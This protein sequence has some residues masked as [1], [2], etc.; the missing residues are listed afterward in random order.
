M[1][2]RCLFG[3]S[4]PDTRSGD[5]ESWVPDPGLG[6][7]V[8]MGCQAQCWAVKVED[9]YQILVLGGQFQTQSQVIWRIGYQT[10]DWG[11]FIRD[12]VRLISLPYIT[13]HESIFISQ[14]N[15]VMLP[16]SGDRALAIIKQDRKF[17][18][19]HNSPPL[20]KAS[21]FC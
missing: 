6:V 12:G 1:G 14:N 17:P 5:M 10:Q 11:W 21:V 8:A 20:S 18:P 4:V 19:R 9:G 2:V 13:G 3:V 16:P 15:W 7:R